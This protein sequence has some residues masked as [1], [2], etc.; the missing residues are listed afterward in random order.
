VERNALRAGLVG[1]AEGWRW[2]SRW[3]RE[4]GRTAGRWDEGP[5]ALPADGVEHVNR[6]ETEAAWEALRRSVVRG[7][8]FGGGGWVERTAQRLGL[9]ATLR[10]PG[11][12]KKARGK[13]AN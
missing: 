11:R 12:R 2:S 5:V 8:P 4:Q 1:R 9:A 6:P 7:C 13:G 10:G 3:H